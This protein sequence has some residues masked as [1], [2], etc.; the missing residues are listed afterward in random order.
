MKWQAT[1]ESEIQK[2]TLKKNPHF[3]RVNRIL[4]FLFP[5]RYTL[6]LESTDQFS[7]SWTEVVRDQLQGTIYRMAAAFTF[8]LN[9]QDDH[10]SGYRLCTAIWIWQ[11]QL[12]D[13]CYSVIVVVEQY[14]PE[15]YWSWN[16]HTVLSV[17]SCED[18]YILS[19]IA[20][21]RLSSK[22]ACYQK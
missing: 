7:W 18:M 21:L 12:H 3:L 11:S 20:H 14:G 10:Y 15:S 17:K 22:R 1:Q 9:Q 16:D 6:P 8:K 5:H 2:Q 4:T 19:S 13:W